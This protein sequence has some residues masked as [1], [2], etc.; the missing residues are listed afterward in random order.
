MGKKEN[1][2]SES[3]PLGMNESE[4]APPG[5]LE[6]IQMENA[7]LQQRILRAQLTREEMLIEETEQALVTR[8]DHKRLMALANRRRQGEL[9]QGRRNA[10]NKVAGCRHRQG[11]FRHKLFTGDGKPMVTIFVMPDGVTRLYQ[12]ARCRMMEYTPHID[13]KAREPKEYERRVALCAKLESLYE[14]SGLDL[15]K[16]PTFLWS[17]NGV[18]FLP[19]RIGDGGLPF[20]PDMVNPEELEVSN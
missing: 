18:P 7:I 20:S 1:D 3:N 4:Q 2:P 15:I 6:Q 19:E 8:K 11:G 10:A 5:I 12:C 13:L 16:G 9:L 17:R 14:E